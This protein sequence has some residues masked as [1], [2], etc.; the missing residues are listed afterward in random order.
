MKN[1]HT[2]GP[3]KIFHSGYVNAPFIIYSGYNAPYI[4]TI[5][6][7]Q[8]Y[9]SIKVVEVKYDESF[10]YE[11]QI[12]NAKLIAAIPDLLAACKYALKCLHELK[13]NT[14][15]GGDQAYQALEQAIKNAE[16]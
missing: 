11:S 6:Q 14:G 9:G 15:D 10:L 3:W 5:G 4:D 7:L 12:A 1:L 16:Q 2:P 13:I 8:M